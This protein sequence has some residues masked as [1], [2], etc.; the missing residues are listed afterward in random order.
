M[1]YEI[2]SELVQRH[3]AESLSQLLFT[4]LFIRISIDSKRDFSCYDSRNHEGY[5]I[6]VNREKPKT[7]FCFEQNGSESSSFHIFKTY[8]LILNTVN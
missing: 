1:R 6:L 5:F 3:C 7:A 4:K 8:L 2:G